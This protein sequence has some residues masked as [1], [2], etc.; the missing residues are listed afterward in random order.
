MNKRQLFP[1][2]NVCLC[3]FPPLVGFYGAWPTFARWLPHEPA[4][5]F[6]FGFVLGFAFAVPAIVLGISISPGEQK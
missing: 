2:G 3:A 5:A 1:A 4:S 6:L